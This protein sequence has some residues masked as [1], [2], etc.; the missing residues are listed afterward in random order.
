MEGRVS[1][2]E[3]RRAQKTPFM[4]SHDQIAAYKLPLVGQMK[5]L[6]V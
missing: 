2:H 5:T 1:V 6:F 3:R 4:S